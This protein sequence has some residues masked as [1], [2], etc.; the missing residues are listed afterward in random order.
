[1][2]TVEVT[3]ETFF[4]AADVEPVTTERN[5]CGLKICAGTCTFMFMH[6]FKN[7]SMPIQLMCYTRDSAGV[8]LANWSTT[9]AAVHTLHRHPITDLDGYSLIHV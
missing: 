8:T 3:K 5:S 1:M 7:S 6:I 4:P 9:A 2:P